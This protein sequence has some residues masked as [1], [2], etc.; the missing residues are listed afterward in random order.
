MSE[1]KIFVIQTDED[2]DVSLQVY[3]NAEQFEEALNQEL[4]DFDGKL[5]TEFSAPEDGISD[6][7]AEST[8][9]VIKG[10]FVIPKPVTTTIKMR[11]EE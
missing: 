9:I 10:K 3:D 8:R 2:G 1:E 11:L 5:H 4:K 6:I 7:S